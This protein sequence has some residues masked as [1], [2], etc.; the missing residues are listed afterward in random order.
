MSKEK[1]IKMLKE[2]E[3]RKWIERAVLAGGAAIAGK[4]LGLY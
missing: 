1:F 3:K 2:A 4:G